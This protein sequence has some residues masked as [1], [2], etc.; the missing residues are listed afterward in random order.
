MRF[1]LQLESGNRQEK[2]TRFFPK[3]AGVVKETL[4]A[5]KK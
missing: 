5:V 1:S 4:P 2:R 3:Q